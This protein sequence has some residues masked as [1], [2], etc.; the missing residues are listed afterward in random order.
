MQC[1]LVSRS[2]VTLA[3]VTIVNVDETVSYA[4]T[5]KTPD[6]VQEVDHV[7]INPG[8]AKPAHDMSTRII[9]KSVV[10]DGVRLAI[11]GGSA[12]GVYRGMAV[13]FLS[14]SGRTIQRGEIREVRERTSFANREGNLDSTSEIARVVVNPA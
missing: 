1:R 10:D 7:I 12:H 8:S 2:G 9:G 13:A 14:E 6:G 11:G 3:N 5:H 4:H